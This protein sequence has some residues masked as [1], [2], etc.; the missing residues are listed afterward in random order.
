MDCTSSNVRLEKKTAVDFGSSK[1]IICQ[2]SSKLKLLSTENGRAELTQAATKKKDDV[3]RRI[4]MVAGP[5]YYH[6]DSK[7]YKR[8]KL[9]ASRIEIVD[10]VKK[11]ESETRAD[12]PERNRR[13][14]NN[15]Y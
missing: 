10:E 3:F 12:E 5:I 15:F 2:K 11:Q 9:E 13:R 1:C 7:C 14:L 8:Y 6:V 4:Q